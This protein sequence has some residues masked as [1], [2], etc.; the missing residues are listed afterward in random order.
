MICGNAFV[1]KPAEDV[2]LCAVSFVRCLAEAGFPPGVFNLVH[3]P[4]EPTG[5]VLVDHA[6][7]DLISFMGS[8]DGDRG[9]G[10]ICAGRHA[11]VSLEMGGKNVRVVLDD[12]DRPW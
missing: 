4:G 6:A 10:A 3:G 2:P 8:S 5:A 9:V 7:V 11:N 12:V 1:L